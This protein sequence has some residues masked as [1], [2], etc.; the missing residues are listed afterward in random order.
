M[1]TKVI[2]GILDYGIGNVK[3][4][5]NALERIGVN[6]LLT[7]N[8][9]EI[10]KADA[11]IFPGVGAFSKGMNNLNEFNLRDLIFKFV[12]TGKPF[13]G[14]CLGMQLLLNESDEFGTTPGLG[15]IKGK[16]TTM[17]LPS[18]SQFKLPHISWNGINI[19]TAGRWDN[20]ILSQTPENADVYFVHTFVAMPTNP[21]DILSTTEYGGIT[22]CSAIHH[23]NVYGVQFHPEK[24]GE[25]GLGIL[26]NFV[27]LIEKKV[28]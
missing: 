8:E 9:T 17:P 19:P 20:T 22:F 7:R 11:L 24:S 3:S 14:V 16:V 4:M 1:S 13:L 26:R 15:L 12:E 28:I 10:L 21:T 25:V 2:V 5:A 18:D 6:P 23:K 27:S